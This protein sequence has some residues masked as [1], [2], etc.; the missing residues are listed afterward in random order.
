MLAAKPSLWLPL[1]FVARCKKKMGHGWWSFLRRK[2]LEN[3]LNLLRLA[4]GHGEW[5]LD[6]SFPWK[7]KV[8]ARPC[9]RPLQRPVDEWYGHMITHDTHMI[10]ATGSVLHDYK[11]VAGS[12]SDLIK[13]CVHILSHAYAGH[14]HIRSHTLMNSHTDDC[15]H[16]YTHIL[17][18]TH[19]LTHAYTF[20]HPW[21]HTN[22]PT[23][24]TSPICPPPHTCSH[25]HTCSSYIY[26][27]PFSATHMGLNM[28]IHSQ[29]WTFTLS[30]FHTQSHIYPH[31]YT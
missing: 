28:V 11:H 23:Y 27:P 12:F 31:M 1:L 24:T 15:T 13:V 19:V 25:S 14:T 5:C 20:L 2:T 21:V 4:R 8:K 3:L 9:R 17:S 29:T 30:I 26:I 6:K 18:T 16:T 7:Y 10:R 22:A